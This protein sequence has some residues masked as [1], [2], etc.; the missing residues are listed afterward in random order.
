MSKAPFALQLQ[1]AVDERDRQPL[2]LHVQADRARRRR[3][4]GRCARGAAR[5]SAAAAWVTARSK[6]STRAES[7]REMM[8]S[9]SEAR[10]TRWRV[11]SSLSAGSRVSSSSSRRLV[12][13]M[14]SERRRTSP[15]DVA[16][17]E[18][19]VGHRERRLDVVDA[20]EDRV[21]R[22]RPTCAARRSGC[23]PAHGHH[24][25]RVAL[26]QRDVREQQRRV[27]RVVE[28]RSS[29]SSFDAMRRPQSITSRTRW[30]FSSS[31][32]RAIRRCGARGRLPVDGALRVALAVLAQL[33]ELHALAAPAH[34][35]HADLRQAVVGGE[36]RVLGER[37]EVGVDAHRRL[38]C[39]VLRLTCHSPSGE[40]SRTSAAPKLRLAARHRPHLVGDLGPLRR[41]SSASA[42]R[43]AL[44]LEARRM[45][46]VQLEP[47]AAS[48][49]A[50]AMRSAH[51]DAHAERERSRHAPRQR[52][53]G[54]AQP[55]EQ[56]RAARAARSAAAS[57]G[58]GS[59]N[60]G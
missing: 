25:D 15:H 5:Y 38:A 60:S 51:F 39:P 54:Q 34:L 41:G 45:V 56:R 23:T 42:P 9:R 36:Q 44:G 24:A 1:V 59:W 46:V 13:T 16:R 27:Q 58:Q 40:K 49:A 30:S 10:T 50:L 26:A 4:G 19:V 6:L 28:V 21:H 29:S 33:V 57:A 7:A 48:P 31:Y 18:V 17:R 8:A 3:C 14:T 20:V 37:A 53:R 11:R 43:Q 32:S 47:H 35:Q 52:R 55:G 2:G 22:A 12:S